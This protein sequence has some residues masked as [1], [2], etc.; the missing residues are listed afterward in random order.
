MIISE[1]VKVK[2]SKYYADLGYDISEKY[3]I[4]KIKDITK[5]SRAMVTAKCDFCE[6]EKE[7]SYKSY[8]DNINRGGKFSCSIKCGVEKAKKSNLEKWG[9]EY[10]T[11]SKYFKEKSK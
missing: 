5:G 2:G 8:N 11:N 4:V 6:Y 10:V 1:F 9:S 3:I 7:I